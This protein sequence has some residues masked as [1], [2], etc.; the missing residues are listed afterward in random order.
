MRF[1]QKGLPRLAR[2]CAAAEKVSPRGPHLR[3]I[4]RYMRQTMGSLPNANVLGTMRDTNPA[5]A[6][7]SHPMRELTSY[8]YPSI[9]RNVS[10]H[11]WRWVYGR[12]RHLLAVILWTVR[13]RLGLALFWA[14]TALCGLALLLTMALY[15]LSTLVVPRE[16]AQKADWMQDPKA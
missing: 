14:S 9:T 3:Q 2:R 4:A 15:F 13:V 12:T 1:R 5:C 7:Y 11:A 6:R 10:G 8:D 16:H